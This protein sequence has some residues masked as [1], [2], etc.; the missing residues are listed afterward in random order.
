[1]E[2]FLNENND[3]GIEFEINTSGFQIFICM[4]GNTEDT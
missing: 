3:D 4:C 1:M 2:F